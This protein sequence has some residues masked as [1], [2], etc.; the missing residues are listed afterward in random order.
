MENNSQL[1]KN[2][3]KRIYDLPVYRYKQQI[4]DLLSDS[5]PAIVVGETGSGKTTQIPKIIYNHYCSINKH[6]RII[7]SQPR[8]VAA[9]SIAHRVAQEVNF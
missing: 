1:P 3:K 9:I 6:P 5:L 4:I 2:E 8:R 7:V